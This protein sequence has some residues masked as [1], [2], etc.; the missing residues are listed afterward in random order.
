MRS[1]SL[2]VND[3]YRFFQ[4]LRGRRPEWGQHEALLSPCVPRR[5]VRE[6]ARLRISDRRC[7]NRGES[8]NRKKR[9]AIHCTKE[10]S[11]MTMMSMIMTMG[12]TNLHTQV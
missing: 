2:S 12:I 9:T 3:R 5:W 6:L 1:D 11:M 4:L 8:G 7:S 10:G